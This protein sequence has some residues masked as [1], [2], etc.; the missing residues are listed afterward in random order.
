[1]MKVVHAKAC[2]QVMD[3]TREEGVFA[4]DMKMYNNPNATILASI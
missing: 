2:N 3:K 4:E 1:M